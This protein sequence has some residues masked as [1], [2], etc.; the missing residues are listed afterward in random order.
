MKC[1]VC[2]CARLA[3]MMQA[4]VDAETV[5]NALHDALIDADADLRKL[6]FNT[7]ANSHL[8]GVK[9]AQLQDSLAWEEYFHKIG[10]NLLKIE[11]LLNTLKQID[12]GKLAV[13]GEPDA[14]E[15]INA[16]DSLANALKNLGDL[17]G[18]APSS[19]PAAD[20][21]VKD[22]I[23]QEWD[24][25]SDAVD[26]AKVEKQASD[27]LDTFGKVNQGGSQVWE[28]LKKSRNLRTLIARKLKEYSENKIKAEKAV[29]KDL[30]SNVGPEQ[31]AI[32]R[33]WE[34]WQKV[35]NRKFAAEDA[36]AAI[37]EAKDALEACMKKANAARSLSR[38]P[39][40]VR[41]QATARR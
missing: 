34:A 19:E 17:R 37:R 38:V 8:T 12:E 9:I 39:R 29:L 27:A 14:R 31:A 10:S 21:G 6:Y 24:V 11:S 7:V 4:L 3:A 20:P 40:S 41:L 30:E 35:R 26:I 36:L 16:L 5:M 33:A 18:L 22:F 2:D 13:T 1:P 25:K 23:N 15:T 28:T 32:T